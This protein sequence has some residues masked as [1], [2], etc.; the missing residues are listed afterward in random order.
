V[1]NYVAAPVMAPPVFGGWGFGGFSIMPTFVM[2][3]PF[4][5]FGTI[6]SLFLVLALV[7]AVF[8]VVSSMSSK[9]SNNDWDN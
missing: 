4:A 7:S 9:K 6:L 3:I 2:P 8:N 5:G 1:N